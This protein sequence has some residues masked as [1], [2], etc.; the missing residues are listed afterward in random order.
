MEVRESDKERWKSVPFLYPFQME[1]EGRNG[2]SWRLCVE[3]LIETLW[4]VPDL[5]LA[6]KTKGEMH[7]P[8]SGHLS[9]QQWFENGHNAMRTFSSFRLTPSSGKIVL[10]AW[11]RVISGSLKETPLMAVELDT[12]V[13]FGS[14]CLDYQFSVCINTFG[15]TLCKALDQFTSPQL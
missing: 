14:V 6:A 13:T 7:C 12:L 4:F 15:R 2:R 10:H 11:T 1:G 5:F 8:S 9:D 3:S